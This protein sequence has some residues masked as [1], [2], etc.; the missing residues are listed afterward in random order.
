MSV[1]FAKI[2]M[3]RGT[4]AEWAAAN[5]VLAQ[6]EMAFETDTGLTK[7][8][9][10][11]T[12][13][14][15]L[16]SYAT[17]DQMLAA[18][19]ALDEAALD[20]AAVEAS[21]V[22]A[23][24]SAAT[25]STKATEAAGS[26]AAALA[27]EQSIVAKVNQ[28]E[29]ARIDAIAYAAVA[30]EKA[31]EIVASAN[32]AAADASAADADRIAAEVARTG[33]EAAQAIAQGAAAGA[34]SSEVAADASADVASGAAASALAIYGS[35]DAQ[36][37]AVAV[38]QA[39][40][41]LA[42][43]FAA[44]AASV[45][46]Q[47]LSGVTAQALH[48]S[49]NAVT[50]MFLYDTSKDS[51]GGA[52]TEKCQHTSWWNEA[53]N[54]R[55]LTLADP[56]GIQSEVEA[57]RIGAAVG[58]ELVTNGGFDSS[59]GWTV[60]ANWSIANGAAAANASVYN[61]HNLDQ[62]IS[63]VAGRTYRVTFN[64]TSY[65]AGSLR[66]DIQGSLS[67]LTGGASAVGSYT[68]HFVAAATNA[69]AVLRISGS[70]GAGFT[71]TIDNIS[72]REVTGLTTAPS[73]YFQLAT[74]GR[75]YRLNK[76]LLSF[77]E[78]FDNAAWNKSTATVSAN[79]AADP[80]GAMTADV[81][82][83][84]GSNNNL[85]RSAPDYGFGVTQTLSVWLRGAAGG[86][87]K[88][89]LYLGGGGAATGSLEV[90]LT[91]TW[92]RVSVTA[93]RGATSDGVFVASVC[94]TRG[95]TGAAASVEVWG[96]QLE[97]G[98]AATAYEAKTTD[99]TLTAT[100]RGN[101]ADFP[102]LAGIVAEAT[103]VNIYDLTEPGR[104][105][106]MRIAKS[107]ADSFG[108]L[109][110]FSTAPCGLFAVNGELAVAQNG[111]NGT[112]AVIDFPKDGGRGFRDSPSSDPN[113]CT[114]GFYT[115][116]ISNRH[117]A[118]GRLDRSNLT[119]ANSTVNA[120]AMTVLPDAPIDPVTGLRVPTIAVATGG[121]VSVIQDEGNVRNSSSTSSFDTVA[122]TPSLLSAGRADGTWYSAANPG[123]L[124]ASFAL[125]QRTNTQAPG[126]GIGNTGKLVDMGRSRLLRRS[127]TAA[128]AQMARA[129]ESDQAR[130]LIATVGDTF[131]TG[132]M[133]GDIRGA[134]LSDTRAGS[135]GAQEFYSTTAQSGVIGLASS[136]WR[137]LEGTSGYSISGEVI[138][139]NKTGTWESIR[140][141]FGIP[142]GTYVTLEIVVT[143]T[144]GNISV[145]VDAG[146]G[147]A[148]AAILA[149]SGTYFVSG[150]PSAGAIGFGASAFVGTVE[151]KS[152]RRSD[153][154]RAFNSRSALVAGT[155][156]RSS[157]ASG[158]SLTGY[159]GFSAANYLREP[160]SA[161]LDFGTGEWTGSAWVNVPAS[162]P[163][164]SFPVIGGDLVTNG[165]FGEA[166]TGWSAQNGAALSIVSGALR[167]T[168]DGVDGAVARA[169]QV[170]STVAGRTYLLTGT[171]PAGSGGSGVIA[172]SPNTSFN[173]QPNRTLTPGQTG[174]V[175]FVATSSTTTVILA[176]N[177][178]GAGTTADFDNV[179]VREVG[180]A[181]IFDRAASTGPRLRLGVTATGNLTAEA[182]DG[183]TTRTVTTSDAYNTTQWL[184]ARVNYTTDGTLAILVNGREVAATRGAPLLT[185][186]NA[187]AV[188]TIGNSFALDAP[189]PG[190]IALLKLGA[191]V[192]TPEQ[193]TFM[194]EQEK[195]LFRAGALSVLPDSG[196]IVDMAYDDA[197]DRWVAMSA[198]N[199]SYWTGL[200]RNSVQAVPAGSFSRVV[201]G[202]G[203]ELA[204]RTGTN[205]GVDVTIPAYGLREELVRRA[206]TAA[207]LSRE[208]VA[209]DFVGGFTANTTNGSAAIT[210]VAGLTYPGSLI[211]ARV[212]GAGIPAN[213][214][215]VGVSGTT[216]YLSAVCT[217]TAT[218]V[219][220]SFLDFNLPVGMETKA[221]LSAGALRR[222]GSTQDYVKIFDGFVE[223][224]RFAVAPGATAW[225]QVHATK[226]A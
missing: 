5:P 29:Q 81:L 189:F 100:F 150:S 172:L 118:E 134:F 91:S 97:I 210:N 176:V 216:I 182:F 123:A 80:N 74:D 40:A 188:L 92:Q 102:R 17:Y 49:P 121:G 152:I 197:T 178:I 2:Q 112:T 105:M 72:V 11:A 117:T 89:L 214:R 106:W 67:V 96:A 113:N 77:S 223:A 161:D 145:Y 124:G 218:G 53:I 184:K 224:V 204:A 138:S 141:N 174:S 36:N 166:V 42:A 114:I 125:A 143:R 147:I 28:A 16:P 18:K 48:R 140:R 33:A 13:Y 26:A 57:R 3:R 116:G 222:E 93:T 10:G 215:I 7:I 146:T 225:V 151:I 32:A 73:D 190:S 142:I 163:D 110:G 83:I 179:S 170:I 127:A 133:A 201:A 148:A 70:T 219:A 31:D 137:S 24:G 58:A 157:L 55:W 175:V 107:G 41:S 50:A 39:Q 135:L 78:Q 52:W 37:T 180:P 203:L 181:I 194:F 27:S 109:P 59:T 8:G 38:A 199:E 162:M 169:T 104:P 153:A 86:K 158:T 35:V 173:V 60:G 183:T 168:D 12:A 186:N 226:G 64:V 1:V 101:K 76:N 212:S 164:G 34:L 207:R 209:F 126:F 19:E 122:L 45:A 149:A 115:G 202:S 103:S 99:G 213:T 171:V 14:A 69:A 46:Q 132:W 192:P 198:A 9:D 195:Q 191:T 119:I 30:E 75:F 88:V 159:S 206:E 62:P 154:D 90:T 208:L 98:S 23:A 196:A 44:S 71:G 21:R 160:Y 61:T 63:L 131:N 144:S 15:T 177:G 84:T 130:S 111:N 6:G 217:A 4:A 85:F 156:T 68:V 129:H 187:S 51:D 155:I 120:V 56:R 82:T 47:D 66:I 54:G 211:G 185:L 200:V 220:V 136:P 167:V 65:T 87:V 165:H 20:V 193:A 205:P 128:R 43:G 221:V 94:D 108:L 22:A 25:A 79:A 139:V 95:V